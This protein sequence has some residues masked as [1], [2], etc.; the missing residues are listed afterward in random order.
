M[1]NTLL[2]PQI[3]AN[4]LLRRMKSN[5][6]FASSIRHEYDERFAVSGGKIG[7]TMSLR[8][9]VRFTAID[10]PTMTSQDVTE[11]SVPLVLNKHKHVGFTF[12]MKDLTLTIDR[13]ADRYLNSA[14]VALANQVDVDGLTMAYQATYNVVGVPG[15][16]PNAIKTYNQAGA[17]LDKMGAPLDGKRSMCIGPDMQ[18]EV[19][20]ALKALFASTRQITSQYEQGRMGTAA[21]FEWILDQNIRTQTT[22]QLGGTPAYVAAGSTASVLK[23]N[24]WTNAVANRLKKGDVIQ[25]AGVYAVNPV[26]GDTL[27]D[28]ANFVVTADVDS[29]GAGLADIPISPAIVSAATPYRNVSAAPVDGALISVYGKAAAQ[30]STVASKL[31]PQGIGYHREAFALAMAP[32]DLPRGTHF[33]A[34]SIDR[35]TGMSISIVSDFN[36]ST[37]AMLT[38]CDILYG[39]AAPLPSLS[40]RIES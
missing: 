10:G 1:P 6:A 20:D 16:I 22:G 27:A 39:W 15:T 28:L 30:Q 7:D 11:T 31:S 33:A 29:T 40:V 34:R 21:G 5:L 12:S 36:I 24:G 37:Y 4:E 38:R 35:E 13:F 2:T 18:V 8:V 14:A 17:W 3:I 25:I 9:P 19:V 26:S 23:S 32:F